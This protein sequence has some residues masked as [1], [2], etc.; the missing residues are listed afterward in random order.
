MFC[1][2]NRTAKRTS[3]TE[4]VLLICRKLTEYTSR[5]PDRTT[6]LIA[7]TTMLAIQKLMLRL[8]RTHLSNLPRILFKL[9]PYFQEILIVGLQ[10]RRQEIQRPVRL[11]ARGHDDV[12]LRED[13][14]MVSHGLIV[15]PERRRERVRI[16]RSGPDQVDDLGA[17]QSPSR[18]HDEVP[19]PLVHS[20]ARS[21]A[22]PPYV[23]FL[24]RP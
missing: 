13:L 6:M 12:V 4:K 3:T 5:R 1:T 2:R 23:R 14:E 7:L 24:R 16:V 20:T 8:I 15:E 11:V 17:V 19:Q 10:P 21:I 22:R 18:P 9:L